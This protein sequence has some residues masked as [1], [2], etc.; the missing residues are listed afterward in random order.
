MKTK[1]E[2]QKAMPKFILIMLGSLLVGALIGV[3]IVLSDGDWTASIAEALKSGLIT[4]S[5]W[6]IWGSAA[7]SALGVFCCYQKAKHAFL[8]LQEDDEAAVEKIDTLLNYG[9]LINSICLILSFFFVGIPFC[10]FKESEA[11]SFLSNLAGFIVC[12]I[13]MAIGQ[14]KIVDLTKKL[15][16]E[17]RGSVYDVKFEKKW[18][19]SC[20]EA[21]RAAIGQAAYHAYKATNMTCLLLWMVLV[22]G[23]MLFD[24]GLMPIAVVTLIW[25]IST[26]SYCL[27][28]MKYGKGIKHPN[29]PW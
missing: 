22:I 9:L 23:N 4:A 7:V 28:A 13:A 19:E 27:H 6:L 21:E 10:F 2:N 12:L 14:Q 26:V 16:P 11:M 5:P 24:F 1:S 17:K 3:G 15:Y 18:F 25:L 29:T 8:V 20:D